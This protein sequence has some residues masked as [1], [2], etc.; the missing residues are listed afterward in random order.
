MLIVLDLVIYC[1][2]EFYLISFVD[3]VC[4][5]DILM[6]KGLCFNRCAIFTDF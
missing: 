6:E 3:F 5:V 1:L 4:K 2:L